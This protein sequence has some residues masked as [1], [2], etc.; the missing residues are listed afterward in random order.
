MLQS[1][2]CLFPT[3]WA[4]QSAI[5]DYGA[6]PARVHV[7]PFG[8]NI[9]AAV[10]IFRPRPSEAACCNLVFIG[11]DWQR[12]GGDIA[13]AA[14]H[15]LRDRGIAATLDIIGA[16]PVLSGRT[17]GI[18]VHGYLDKSTED[19]SRRFN[20]L[21]RDAHF[22]LVPTRQDCYGVFAAEANAFGVPVISTRTGGVPG[23]VTDGANGYLLPLD[24]GGSD[25]AN[26]IAALWASPTGYRALRASS[27]QQ[28]NTVLNWR[29]WSVRAAK[30][31][32]ALML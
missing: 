11:M 4:A 16:A 23:A 9:D 27:F 17:D 8:A 15:H 31:V 6:D 30:I 22:V 19:G 24:A 5:R 25:Y 20:K 10:P 1:Q 18:K 12:K 3:A 32:D 7:I 29:S 28:F 13:V 2:A 21:L 14:L 26:V